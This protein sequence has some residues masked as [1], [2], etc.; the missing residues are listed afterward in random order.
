MKTEAI[1]ID[2]MTPAERRLINALTPTERKEALLF[3]ARERFLEENTITCAVCG[4]PATNQCFHEH[5]EA[6][7]T[8]RE[9]AEILGL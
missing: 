3:V 5:E 7:K 6:N 9:T 2:V 1:R 4:K 8:Y